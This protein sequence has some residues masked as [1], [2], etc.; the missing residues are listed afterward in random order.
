VP[1]KQAFIGQGFI[2]LFRGVEHHFD[3]AFYM[4]ISWYEPGNVHTEPA[5]YG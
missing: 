1:V 3:N 4:P 5:G 2:E